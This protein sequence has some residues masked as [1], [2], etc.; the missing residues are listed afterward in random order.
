MDRGI[1]SVRCS[2]DGQRQAK[3]AAKGR[4]VFY[5]SGI[6]VERCGGA[7]RARK[8]ETDPCSGLRMSMG[9]EVGSLSLLVRRRVRRSGLNS[10]D[11][12]GDVLWR[13][14]RPIDQGIVKELAY[15]T[16]DYSPSGNRISR[17]IRQENQ[18]FASNGQ[19]AG[20]CGN[21]RPPHCGSAFSG[22][23]PVVANRR[24]NR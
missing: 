4:L 18:K 13:T 23:E 6:P 21:S 2:E 12:P 24:M 9:V 7:T 11:R 20:R 8:A 15:Q 5:L 17:K 16:P 14:A 3:P 10:A 22:V 19:Q 1:G